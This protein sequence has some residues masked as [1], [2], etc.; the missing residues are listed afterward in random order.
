M[1]AEWR[2]ERLKQAERNGEVVKLTGAR[3]ISSPGDRPAREVKRD[4]GDPIIFQQTRPSA[5]PAPEGSTVT[6]TARRASDGT[7]GIHW[8]RSDIENGGQHVAVTAAE[9]AAIAAAVVEATGRE[10]KGK[11]GDIR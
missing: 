2:L 6:V 10:Q 11:R 9:F 7:V 5:W 3:S 1:S 4:V 8:E